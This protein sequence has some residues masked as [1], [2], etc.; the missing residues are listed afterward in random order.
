MEIWKENWKKI[1]EH[2]KQADEGKKSYWMATNHVSDMTSEESLS[3]C[4]MP[5]REQFGQYTVKNET[6]NESPL[7]QHVD[8]RQNGCVTAAKNQNTPNICSSCW[9]FSAVGAIES[10]ICIKTGHLNSLSEQQIMDCGRFAYPC[11]RDYPENALRYI[12]R[13]RGLVKDKDYPYK[14]TLSHTAKIYTESLLE[15]AKISLSLLI[16]YN[17][18]EK[19]LKK[20]N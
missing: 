4:C 5:L 2:N 17:I 11:L 18:L 6:K 3:H 16:T 1:Q 20:I 15:E 9:I 12:Q 14:A 10:H 13:A 19:S 8:W 7:L